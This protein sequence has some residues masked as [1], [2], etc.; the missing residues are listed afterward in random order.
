MRRLIESPEE[1]HHTGRAHDR[2]PTP[3][4]TGSR[5]TFRR[6]VSGWLPPVDAP[7]AKLD[8]KRRPKQKAWATSERFQAGAQHVYEQASERAGTTSPGM[9]SRDSRRC[10]QARG[11]AY[12]SAA[13]VLTLRLSA[14]GKLSAD[15]PPRPSTS[16]LALP[17]VP[18]LPG[19]AY[20]S[21]PPSE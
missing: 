14:G 9:L 12:R 1:F 16:D 4:R 17:T 15:G 5:P 19:Y 21:T 20:P 7:T 8:V 6:Q 10:C 2:R 18:T 3:R 13:A 11:A